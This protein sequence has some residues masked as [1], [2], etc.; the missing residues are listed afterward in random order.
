MLKKMCLL[1]ALL[2]LCVCVSKV[3]EEKVPLRQPKQI[4]VEELDRVKRILVGEEVAEISQEKSPFEEN[5]NQPEGE[6]MPKYEYPF[7]YIADDG[8][9]YVVMILHCYGGESMYDMFDFMKN[10][11]ENNLYMSLPDVFVFEQGNGKLQLKYWGNAEWDGTIT[12]ERARE[13]SDVDSNSSLVN[14]YSSS[15]Y[16]SEAI[17]FLCDEESIRKCFKENGIDNI[18][19][20]V[21]IG[22]RQGYIITAVTESNAYYMTVPTTSEKYGDFIFQKIYTKEEFKKIYGP[23]AA[24]VFVN[25]KEVSFSTQVML[26]GMPLGIGE[27]YTL[28]MDVL[29]LAEMLGVCGVYNDMTNTITI[30]DIVMQME[31]NEWNP[32][33][34]YDEFIEDAP[35]FN[36]SVKAYDEKYNYTAV[37][38][39]RNG[40]YLG[41]WSINKFLCKTLGYEIEVH[42]EDYSIH[43]SKAVDM[44]SDR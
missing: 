37:L 13:F 28:E 12:E 44:K 8:K 6:G 15:E 25:G 1:L 18:Q 23:R 9:E 14:G 11:W 3:T 5:V 42:L 33:V 10:P 32:G 29:E 21:I 4:S 35:M 31:E 27:Q 34:E 26:V 22:H 43:I 7:T 36:V 30:G 24:K 19:D 40:R 2:I 16:C 17:A 38:K 39:Y 20:V 41:S